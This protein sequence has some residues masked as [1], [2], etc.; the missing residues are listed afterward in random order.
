MR[1]SRSYSAR[2]IR[3]A[4]VMVALCAPLVAFALPASAAAGHLYLGIGTSV[5][6]FPLQKG[7]PSTQP[8]LTIAHYG[9][10]IAVA[11]DGTVYAL[12]W[13]GR[14]GF[15]GYDIFAFPA[16]QTTPSRE[17]ILPPNGMCTLSSP[18]IQ[19]LAVDGS[20]NL[21]VLV[22]YAQS[23]A[24]AHRPAAHGDVFPICLGF[25]VFPPNANGKVKP[26]Q[27]VALNDY[28]FG[29]MAVSEHSNL[30][31]N[32]A[33]YGQTLEYA[34][35]VQDPHQTRTFPAQDNPAAATDR[36][37]D[38]YLLTYGSGGSEINVFAPS[39]VSGPP[40]RSIL[41]SSPFN[42]SVGI[43]IRG[44]FAYLNVVNTSS[45]SVGV[46]DA[47]GN[48]SENP[49]AVLNYANLLPPIAVGP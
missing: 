30:Y 15:D 9:G 1:W 46:Y 11:P 36:V 23:G 28:Y 25:A 35:A 39:W 3:H 29:G 21:F 22:V 27:A 13:R 26:L 24:L 31:I 44:K 45:G 12:R 34:N 8:D 5:E 37:G 47:G 38:L 49:I 32:L 17:I 33:D 16:G 10:S 18:P 2:G 41:L 19:G 42:S 48:G 4:A 6:R 7:I 20:G 43:A 14:G 40:T